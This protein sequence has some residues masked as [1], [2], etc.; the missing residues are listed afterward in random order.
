M[1]RVVADTNV[2]VSAVISGGKPRELLRRCI[3]GQV[4][5]VLSPAILDE[6]VD[7]L[8]RPKFEMNEEEVD[9]IAWALIQTAEFVE[10]RSSLQVVEEDPDDDVILETAVDGRAGFVVSGDKHLLG[11]KRYE[12]VRILSVAGFLEVLDAGDEPT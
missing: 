6:V 1:A 9:R 8:G 3:R 4:D 12:D 11:L 7:V 2:M 10:A 5:L